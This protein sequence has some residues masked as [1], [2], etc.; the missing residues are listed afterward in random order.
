MSVALDGDAIV[1]SASCGV[2]EA[3]SLLAL[4]Q[5]NPGLAV[6]VAAAESVHTAL[7]QVIFAFSPAIRGEPSDPF[8]RQWL[9][10]L[11]TGQGPGNTATCLAADRPC[12]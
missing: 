10:P 5:G 12:P 11:V 8:I 4:V 1:L 3:E 2:E 9:L 7:W 6:D